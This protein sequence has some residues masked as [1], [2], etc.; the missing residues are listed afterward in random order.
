[1]KKFAEFCLIHLLQV[2]H[3]DMFYRHFVECVFFFNGYKKH[4][5]EWVLMLCLL[6]F[7]SSFLPPLPPLFPPSSLILPS[8]LP[9]SRIRFFLPSLL[10]S[11]PPSLY[12]PFFLP[13]LL[14][15]P[16]ILFFSSLPPSLLP[17]LFPLPSL[18]SPSSLLSLPRTLPLLLLPLPPSPSPSLPPSSPP[19][20]LPHSSPFVSLLV[21]LLLTTKPCPSKSNHFPFQGQ[22]YLSFTVLKTPKNPPF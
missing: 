11:L 16:P 3:P 4:K 17:S 1:M 14:P 21:L 22:I 15:L 6:T 9:T 10:L 13:S 12:S 5:G 2:R 7:P 8:F 18:S 19:P 20:S